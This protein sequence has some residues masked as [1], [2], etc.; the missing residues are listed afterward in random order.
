MEPA[1][2]VQALKL[3]MQ[4]ATAVQALTLNMEPATTVQALILNMEPATTV[5]ALT[6][7]IE[8]AATNP[9]AGKHLHGGA[10]ARPVDDQRVSARP[11]PRGLPAN[12][13]SNKL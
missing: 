4:P 2:A 12:D 6:L 7:N 10:Q 8:P 3:N 1:T 9:G 5:Q 11:R 13:H